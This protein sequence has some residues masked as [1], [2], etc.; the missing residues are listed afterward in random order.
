MREPG[1]SIVFPAF[2]EA[3]NLRQLYEEVTQ[4]LDATGVSFELVFVDDGST[5]NSLD[6]IK[7][8]RAMDGRVQFVSLS[9]SF[10]HQRALVAGLTHT[11]GSAV[12]TMDADLQHPPSLLPE[13]IRLWR[14]GIE[15]VYTQ[16][17]GYATRGLRHLEVRLGYWL[18]GKASGLRLAFGQSDFCLLDRRVVDVVL[19]VP[20][21]RKLLRGLVQW[22]GFRQAGLSYRP[23]PRHAGTPKY[24][25]RQLSDLVV[26]GIVS[27]SLLPVRSALVIGGV[28]TLLAFLAGVTGLTM[29]VLHGAGL[30]TVRVP[31]WVIADAVLALLAGVQLMTLGI[32]GE[33]IGRTFEQTKG[34]PEFI[35]RETSTT[36]GAQVD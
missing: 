7:R 26:N 32:L 33:Y 13:M 31:A 18:L 36:V 5:D 6:I 29:T 4:V 14:E 1:L 15:V 22:V 20:E 10:G 28:V 21:T 35:V 11:R 34:R 27:F 16:K 19:K 12:I 3:E 23:A 30:E 25:F 8:L 24:T 17:S 2:N 9:R